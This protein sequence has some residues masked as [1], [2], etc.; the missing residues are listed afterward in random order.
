V[1]VGGVVCVA[2]LNTHS[3]ESL[4]RSRCWCGPDGADS[5]DVRQGHRR[6]QEQAA[7]PLILNRLAGGAEGE[8][9][10]LP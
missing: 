2:V 6:E 3:N 9:I 8:A 7:L 10:R 4:S 1:W 5:F